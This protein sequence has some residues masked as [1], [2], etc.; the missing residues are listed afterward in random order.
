M[1][2]FFIKP[3][4][5]IRYA[6]ADTIAVSMEKRLVE[7][8]SKWNLIFYIKKTG[9]RKNYINHKDVTNKENRAGTNF[10][11]C[12]SQSGVLKE[13]IIKCKLFS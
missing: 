2:E 5:I 6:T 4:K 9:H 11:S 3:R 1:H 12:E 8:H 13:Y 7:E 10:E